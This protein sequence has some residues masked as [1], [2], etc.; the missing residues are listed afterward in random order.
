MSA[1]GL[2]PIPTPLPQRLRQF[3]RTL[4]PGV[5]LGVALVAIGCL[6]QQRMGVS[7]RG[8]EAEA[9][10]VNVSSHPTSTGFPETQFQTNSPG[11]FGEQVS[12]ADPK[13]MEAA[14]AE[15]RLELAA[16]RASRDPA[17]AP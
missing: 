11:Q 1:P 7:P 16:L 8:G 9:G 3:Q 14:L 15:I 17:T 12:V 6:W 4:L 2:N 13:T 10:R 5:V